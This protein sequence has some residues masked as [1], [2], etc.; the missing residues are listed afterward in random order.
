MYMKDSP[1]DLRKRYGEEDWYKVQFAKIEHWNKTKQ[2]NGND[3]TISM[4]ADG[5]IWVTMHS[6]VARS[7][8][9]LDHTTP[10]K[11]FPVKS[12]EE[13]EMEIMKYKMGLK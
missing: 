1:V 8:G 3:Y 2:V 4:W 6:D 11:S 9:V 13:A 12:M 10:D 5:S 7:K